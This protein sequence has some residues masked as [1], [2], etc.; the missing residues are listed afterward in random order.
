MLP[1]LARLITFF[2]WLFQRVSLVYFETLLTNNKEIFYNKW[3]IATDNGNNQFNG[4]EK[5]KPNSTIITNSD[6]HS[7]IDG[8]II[9]G[10]LNQ[11]NAVPVKN[12]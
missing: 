11:N 12:R 9:K 8:K 10:P 5:S 3:S 1:Q 4:R 2:K 7:L 6:V